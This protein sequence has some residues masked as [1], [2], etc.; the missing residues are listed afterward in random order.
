MVCDY[1]AAPLFAIERVEDKGELIPEVSLTTFSFEG[2]A[3]T[4]ETLFEADEIYNYSGANST[5]RDGVVSCTPVCEFGFDAAEGM[6]TFNLSAPG[7][8]RKKITVDAKYRSIESPARC[9]NPHA[10]MRLELELEPLNN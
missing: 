2:T 4:P 6:Y 7:Y 8:V 3:S 9:A 10:P 1:V 5:I